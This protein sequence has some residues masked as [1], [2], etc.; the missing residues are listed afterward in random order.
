V[1]ADEHDGVMKKRATKQPVIEQQLAVQSFFFFTHLQKSICLIFRPLAKN[2]NRP[3]AGKILGR[4]FGGGA[5][6]R[7]SAENDFSA[8][9]EFFKNAL[10]AL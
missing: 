3:V 9:L 10:T 2:K 5:G 1:L 6:Q 4:E 8:P 7:K